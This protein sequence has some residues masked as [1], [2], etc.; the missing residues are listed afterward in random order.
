[1]KIALFSEGHAA[2]R[3]KEVLSAEHDVTLFVPKREHWLR[4]L[5]RRE[6]FVAKSELAAF[7]IDADLIVTSGFPWLLP[8]TLIDRAPRGAIN[9]HPSLLPRH[10][11][12]LPLFWIYHA[13]D[14][15][16]G[17]TV[18]RLVAAADAG[19]VLAQSRFELPRGLSVRDLAAQKQ[20]LGAQMLRDVVARIDSIEGVPQ[21]HSAATQ[22]P[23]VKR[24]TSMIDF[25][26]WPAERV[27]HFLHGLHP[28]FREPVADYRGVGAWESREHDRRPGSVEDAPD[29]WLLYC[30]DGIVHLL[31]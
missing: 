23:R 2:A 17:V 11:G 3:A 21:D 9:A 25:E 18:H 29:G 26:T 13:D 19:E 10:R 8:Q 27:W 28:F 4:R 30:R 5:F 1:M 7:R 22:A 15:E 14:R 31:R 16:T 6:R 20:Q 12:P 24:G